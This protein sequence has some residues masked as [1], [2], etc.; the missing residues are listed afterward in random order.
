MI[1]KK[2]LG[3]IT[4]TKDLVLLLI[5]GGLYN[6]S[7]ALS[8]TFVNVYLWKQSQSFYALGIYNITTVIVQPIVFIFAGKL[9]KVIDRVFV[10]KL[11]VLFLAL[12]YLTVLYTGESASEYIIVLG[13]ILGIGY[14]FFWLAYNL[15]TFEITDPENRDFFNGFSGIMSSVGGMIG[16]FLAGFIITN[17]IGDKGYHFIFTVSMF[18][19]AVAIV[20]SFF[21]S[22]RPAHG[23]YYFWRIIQ[24]RRNN[25]NWRKI[26]TAHI[27]QG[28]REGTF[29]FVISV[30]LFVSTGS[31]T[32][33]GTFG[34]I[35]SGIGLVTYYAASRFI[36][37]E[38]RNQSIL[39]GAVGLLVSIVLVVW[40]VTYIKLLMYGVSIAIF[41]PLLLVPYYSLTYD[42][43]GQ[44]WKAAE[45][46]VEYI[47]VREVFLNIGRI[48]SIFFFLICISLFDIETVLPY[49]LIILGCAYI[50]LYLN[51]RGIKLE[52]KR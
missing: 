40:N 30:F 51:I 13:S 47:V 8:N 14:G 41:Y 37:K 45:M 24:E 6:L 19:F 36:K 28:L 52:R 44:S 3:D 4:V 39:I 43:I 42:I 21:F 23:A 10:L 9:V 16:P 17:T 2:L 18:F 34:L 22:R 20:L 5:I 12:F 33:L 27:C 15:L 11:G 46:R 26:T 35:N 7:V 48:I 25:F 50:L 38:Y 29:L 1:V 32:S 49:I 31:E